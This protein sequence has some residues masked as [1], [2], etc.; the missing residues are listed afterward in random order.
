MAKREL[1]EIN[2]S[3]MADIAFLLLVFFLVT[4][5][6]SK[7][8]EV[9]EKLPRKNEDLEIK[10][11]EYNILQILANK[12]DNILVEGEHYLD[13]PM[14]IAGYVK[15]FFVHPSSED[16]VKWPEVTK[17]TSQMCQTKIAYYQPYTADPTLGEA[18]EDSIKIYEGKL[19]TCELMGGSYNE[20][21]PKA[22]IAITLDN[23]TKYETYINVLDGILTG[24][25]EL[26]DELSIAKFNKPYAELDKDIAEEKEMIEAIQMVYPKRIFKAK[27]IASND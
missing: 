3:S 27:G 9:E 2:A 7:E 18:Y 23:S 13:D 16:N 4:T 24:L 19:K 1:E 12:N 22:V 26:R 11:R 15:D 17:V 6:F 25:T 10:I 8:T 5:T 20:I 21:S 14:E